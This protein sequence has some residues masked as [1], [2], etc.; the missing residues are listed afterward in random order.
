MLRLLIALLLVPAALA[1]EPTRLHLLRHGETVANQT[2]KYTKETL[3]VLSERGEEQVRE[4]TERLLAGPKFD[5]IVVSPVPRA[6]MSIRPYLERSKSVAEIW[7]AIAECCHQKDKTIRADATLKVGQPVRIA[8]EDRPYFR[9][10]DGQERW[11]APADY[12]EGIKQVEKLAAQL[13]ERFGG[14]EKRVLWVGHGIVGALLAAKLRGKKLD[15]SVRLDNGQ[16]T[17]LEESEDGWKL[18]QHNGK[19]VKK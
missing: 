2:G 15:L 11:F 5:A 13:E 14:K 3:N 19:P 8:P 6:M 16:V 12:A 4:L 7:P 18:I 9:V 17:V 10:L 1:A